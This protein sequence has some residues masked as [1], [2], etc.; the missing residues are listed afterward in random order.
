MRVAELMNRHNPFVIPR[1]Y[2]VQ[3]ALD[4]LARG[5]RMPLDELIAALKT[6][7]EDNAVT[8]KFAAR[9]PEWARQKPGCSDLSCS[10]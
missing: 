6:P 10:S 4:G 8:R 1:N 5:D 2:L 9:R 7:Y 3:Q